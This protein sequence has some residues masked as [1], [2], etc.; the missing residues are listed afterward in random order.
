MQLNFIYNFTQETSL[1]LKEGEY[2]LS[3][4]ITVCL[5]L[6]Y[7]SLN[8]SPPLRDVSGG[9]FVI[10]NEELH[11]EFDEF[12]SKV[13]AYVDKEY[14]I[15][16]AVELLQV[17]CRA[18]K[19]ILRRV[20]LL[21][22]RYF[23]MS[24][25]HLDEF[26]E[27]V[28][29]KRRLCC[30][31]A[32]FRVTMLTDPCIDSSHFKYS[33]DAITYNPVCRDWQISR[34]NSLG[35]NF[36][37]GNNPHHGAARNEMIGISQRPIRTGRISADG[38]CFFRC[39]SFIITGSQDYHEELRLLVTTYMAH[40]SSNDKLSILL[41]P[42]MSMQSYITHSKMQSPGEWATEIEIT[43]TSCLLNTAICVFAYTGKIFEWVQYSP[44]EAKSDTHQEE[45]IY[46]TNVHNHFEPVKKM[47]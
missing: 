17:W 47:M 23:M 7:R 12:R 18:S 44:H 20:Q 24:S 14:S 25:T 8:G 19:V 21:G 2:A 43:A 30:D 46:I 10:V 39:I 27:W 33:M 26:C 29:D 32:E 16:E 42:N 1:R 38:N 11:G 34:C 13:Y 4:D 6:E 3:K 37:Y 41:P 45:C 22:R 15:V 9:D 36:H 28:H 35:L 5:W 40:N 31:E